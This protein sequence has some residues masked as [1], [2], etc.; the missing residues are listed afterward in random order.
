VPKSAKKS[1]GG[2]KGTGAK[3]SIIQKG[4]A[5]KQFAAADADRKRVGSHRP[6]E[7]NTIREISCRVYNERKKL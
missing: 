6:K 4:R 5:K 1:G 2:T 7:L 3:K